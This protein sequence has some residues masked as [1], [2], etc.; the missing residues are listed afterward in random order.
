M[1]R[2]PSTKTLGKALRLGQ[3]TAVAGLAGH[4][5]GEP[6]EGEP[7]VELAPAQ[8]DQVA[9]IRPIGTLLGEK[10]DPRLDRA[11]GADQVMAQPGAEQLGQTKIG[12]AR[13]TRSARRKS[14]GRGGGNRRRSKHHSSRG[15]DI[16]AER[17]GVWHDVLPLR[18]HNRSYNRIMPL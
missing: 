16:D 2:P 14:G 5:E 3:R 11:G 17:G 9:N 10:V 1:T 12:C 18:A 15:L 13:S 8:A 6:V 7:A 4:A